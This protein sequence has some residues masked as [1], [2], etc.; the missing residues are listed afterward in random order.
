MKLY[1][2]MWPYLF[3]LLYGVNI[4]ILQPDTD[5]AVL[6]YYR[7]PHFDNILLLAL[8]KNEKVFYLLWVTKWLLHTHVT[9]HVRKHGKIV[10]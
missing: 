5:A 1:K 4:K 2:T 6:M 3:Y 10:K 7:G 8:K 9:L